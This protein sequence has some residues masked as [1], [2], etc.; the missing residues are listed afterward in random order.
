MKSIDSIDVA[1][2]K[3][4]IKYFYTDEEKESLYRLK[5]EY[6]REL[7]PVKPMP[8][9]AD[10]LNTLKETGIQRVLVTGS[11]QRSLIDRITADFPGIFNEDKSSPR[12]MS[13]MASLI[14]NRS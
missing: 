11:G 1:F 5:T 12:A 13:L 8:G 10:M 2:L 3:S 9:A 4:P 6:F 14:P 7:P